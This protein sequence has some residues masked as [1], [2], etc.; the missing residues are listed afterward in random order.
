MAQ[1][2]TDIIQTIDQA[3][4]AKLI[5]LEWKLLTRRAGHELLLEVDTQLVARVRINLVEQLIDHRA[6]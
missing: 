3:V 4:L 6:A 1:G 5:D 2:Q